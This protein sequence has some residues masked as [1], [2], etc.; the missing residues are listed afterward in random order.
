M[1]FG[2]KPNATGSATSFSVMK[3]EKNSKCCLFPRRTQSRDVVILKLCW[4]IKSDKMN[5]TATL[6]TES[7]SGQMAHQAFCLLSKSRSP[8][9]SGVFISKIFN[10]ILK[11]LIFVIFVPNNR[12]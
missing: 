11:V 9:L 12:R 4:S 2:W 7:H 6:Q 5:Q 8:F 1:L 3:E 10:L